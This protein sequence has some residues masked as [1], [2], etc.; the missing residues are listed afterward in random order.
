MARGRT[1]GPSWA[2]QPEAS[3]AV[4]SRQGL[5]WSW[6]LRGPRGDGWSP[7]A[8]GS[9]TGCWRHRVAR[10]LPGCPLR[11]ASYTLSLL[12]QI[13]PP[14]PTISLASKRTSHLTDATPRSTSG[15]P[16]TGWRG[17]KGL[18]PTGDCEVCRGEAEKQ[19]FKQCEYI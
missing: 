11:T 5:S 16:T 6:L 3:R 17:R 10:E 9:G 1:R 4:G 8:A 2:N 12:A 13:P 15:S 14:S 7:R 19:G 18:R